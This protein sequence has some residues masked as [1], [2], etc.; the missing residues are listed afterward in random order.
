MH[1]L[2]MFVRRMGAP[3]ETPSMSSTLSRPPTTLLLSPPP[4]PSTALALPWNGG[5]GSLAARR[6]APSLPNHSASGEA[7]PPGFAYDLDIAL[8]SPPPP[9]RSRSYADMVANR[10]KSSVEMPSH[11]GTPS[12]PGLSPLLRRG[13]SL[14]LCGLERASGGES[15]ILGLQRRPLWLRLA[16]DVQGPPC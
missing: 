12:K 6:G 5:G 7:W 10:H 14:P 9:S 11:M 3:P 8:P 4:L 1:G 15:A 2:A 16:R 13:G